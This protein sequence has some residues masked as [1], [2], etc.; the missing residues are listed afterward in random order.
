VRVAEL[1]HSDL[2]TVSEEDTLGDA[3][4]VL[5][6]AHVSGIPVL[7]SDDRL[8]GVLSTTDLLDAVAEAGNAE[9][10]GRIFDETLVR[11]VMTA[12]PQTIGPEDDVLDA[13]RRML[14]LEIRRLFV[15]MEGKLVGVISQTDIVGALG[16][17]KL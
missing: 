17:D 12:R 11:D 2:R 13:A 16:A 9:E 8:V 10:R 1:M 3:L 5:A 7:D 6:A 15:E 4:E 14:Y